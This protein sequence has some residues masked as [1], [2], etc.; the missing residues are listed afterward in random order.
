M[1]HRETD[2]GNVSSHHHDTNPLGRKLEAHQGH[3]GVSSTHGSHAC[4]CLQVSALNLYK[5]YCSWREAQRRLSSR[6]H[7]RARITCASILM[8]VPALHTAP[9]PAVLTATWA[10][11]LRLTVSW[12]IIQFLFFFFLVTSTL[13]SR[14][15]FYSAAKC[16]QNPSG[17]KTNHSF[18][19]FELIVRLHWLAVEF[20]C[21]SGCVKC[22]WLLAIVSKK[23]IMADSWGVGGGVVVVRLWLLLNNKQ[24]LLF[25]CPTRPW[26]R[27]PDLCWLIK[28]RPVSS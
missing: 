2:Q 28:L 4:W 27:N 14:V 17:Y 19:Y 18:P 10:S 20:I 15:C 3:A 25:Y 7:R 13:S 5:L 22:D 12:L 16:S 1:E 24:L 21:W 11:S 6:E 26:S 8:S 9:F 23:K